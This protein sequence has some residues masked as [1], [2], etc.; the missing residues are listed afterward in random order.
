MLT[1]YTTR[2]VADKVSCPVLLSNGNCVQT[3]DLP[4]GRHFAVW[5]D[6]WPKPCYLFAL[7]AGDLTARCALALI[8]CLQA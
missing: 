3:G 5:E 1:R 2:L 8:T 7:V 6:P 4:A